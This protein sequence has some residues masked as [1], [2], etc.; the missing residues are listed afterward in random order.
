MIIRRIIAWKFTFLFFLECFPKILF[1]LISQLIKFPIQDVMDSIIFF[2]QLS[3]ETYMWTCSKN[4]FYFYFSDKEKTEFYICVD[5]YI[6]N[7]LKKKK[8]NSK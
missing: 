1:G 4:S 5:F 8:F 7:F 2:I 6:F 3:I